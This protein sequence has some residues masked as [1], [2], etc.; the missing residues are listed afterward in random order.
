[1]RYYREHRKEYIEFLQ[2]Q[3]ILNG[4]ID[5]Y[6]QAFQKTQ[7]HSPCFK[8]T[9]PS[10]RYNKVEEYIIEVERRDLKRRAEDAERALHL[11]KELLDLKEAELRKSLDIY[12][13]LYVAKWIDHKKTKD[14]IRDLDFRGIYYSN[15]QIYEIIKRI[16]NEIERESD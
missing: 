8:D 7:P 4:V 16:R 9:R 14:I 1:M 11:K 13:L 12:D 15:T 10:G 6:L 2:A 5:D 3:S